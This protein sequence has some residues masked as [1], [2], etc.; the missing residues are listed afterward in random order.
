[1]P[2]DSLTWPAPL[3]GTR[4]ESPTTAARALQGD[5][6]A[7]DDLFRTHNRRVVLTLISRGIAPDAARDLAQAAWMRLYEQQQ[8]RRLPRLSL[9]GLVVTQ[10]MYLAK[11]RARGGDQRFTHV[12][13]DYDTAATDNIAQRLIDRNR[14]DRAHDVLSGC[15]DSAQRVFRAIYTAPGSSAAEVADQTGLSVQ[16]VRQIV[17]EVR[18]KLRAAMKEHNDA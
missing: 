2:S 12:H 8:R 7:W 13:F 3:A 15:S 18:K 10:A 6:A 4:G 14:L 9:P 11:D 5:S 17:C 16:R 1:M